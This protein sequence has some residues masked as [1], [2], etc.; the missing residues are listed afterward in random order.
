[1]PPP[2]S[3]RWTCWSRCADTLESWRRSPWARP[4]CHVIGARAAEAT[5]QGVRPARGLRDRSRPGAGNGAV[6]G[7]SDLVNRGANATRGAA[8][9]AIARL[10]FASTAHAPELTT[11]LAALAADPDPAVRACAADAIAALAA[12]DSPPPPSRSPGS[13]RQRPDRDVRRAD[14]QPPAALRARAPSRGPQPPS[15]RRARR[16][17]DRGSAAGATWAFTWVY[18]LLRGDV[19]THIRTLAPAARQGGRRGTGN[20]ALPGCRGAYRPPRRPR[21]GRADRGGFCVSLRLD[22]DQPAA[23]LFVSALT[24]SA[25]AEEHLGGLS[26]RPGPQ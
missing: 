16:P 22:L 14:H 8:A 5:V 1:M 17:R 25:A 18:E 7:R 21:R 4:S 24:N 6:P 2:H 10:L 3:L 12:T 9:A 26:R 23:Q 19:P 13:F 20:Q 15:G 11:P